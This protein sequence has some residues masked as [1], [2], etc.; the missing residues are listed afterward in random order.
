MPRAVALLRGI[1]VGGHRKVP[2]ADLRRTFEA[3]GCTEVETYLQSGNVVFHPPD[4]GPAK[5]AT[6]IEHQMAA[7]FA[8]EVSVLVRTGADMAR[9][10]REHPFLADGVDEATLHVTFLADRPTPAQ[11][12]ALSPPTG[13]TDTLV[14]RRREVYLH[15]PGGYGATKLTN[16]FFERHLGITATTRNWRTVT[17]LC[18]LTR[19]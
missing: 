1:N 7:D 15:C 6:A 18:K 5:L 14:V 4:P 19:P 16:S 10:G 9:L 11:V 12:R 3:L 8:V 17:R 2:M 13:S